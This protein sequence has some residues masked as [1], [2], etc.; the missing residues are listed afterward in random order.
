MRVAAWGEAREHVLD[1]EGAGGAYRQGAKRRVVV[2]APMMVFVGDNCVERLERLRA[3]PAHVPL[4][5][6]PIVEKPEEPETPWREVR[7]LPI[8]VLAMI[9]C[10]LLFGFLLAR[11]G[12][13]AWLA[14]IACGGA[15]L[16]PLAMDTM[17]LAFH[18]GAKEE[19]DWGPKDVALA[20]LVLYAGTCGVTAWAYTKTADVRW[21]SLIAVTLACTGVGI[22]LVT[23]RRRRLLRLI[24]SASPHEVPIRDGVWGAVDG[25]ART[26]VGEAS[27][28]GWKVI[29][30]QGR[31]ASGEDREYVVRWVSEIVVGDVAVRM[32]DASWLSIVSIVVESKLG[33]MSVDTIREGASVRVVGRAKD[34][35]I[36]KGGEESLLVFAAD[37]DGDAKTRARQLAK[38][39]AVMFGLSIVGSLILVAATFGGLSL[40]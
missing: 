8:G 10:V 24:A 28:D 4:R 36:A 37:T 34:G 33:R 14:M 39:D 15:F 29:A 20:Y 30:A 6:P 32:S 17:G 7:A 25:R 16:L 40:L 31:K 21:T 26:A 2:M 3:T 9:P 12:Q 19:P 38:W 18:K 1:G 23:S 13:H 11:G 35:V 5:P 22:V 27:V